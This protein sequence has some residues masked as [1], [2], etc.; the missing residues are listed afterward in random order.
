MNDDAKSSIEPDSQSSLT[1]DNQPLTETDTH[2]KVQALI[3]YSLMSIGLF[4][5]LFW[6]IGGIWAIFKRADAVNSRYHSH[7]N[8]AVKVFWYGLIW[9]L[10]GLMLSQV[11]VGYLI[12]AFI[13]IWAMYR[14]VKGFALITSDKPFV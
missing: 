7:F 13:Y 3:S 14:L 11:L 8:N 4:T 6:I 2:S 9:S 5:G 1:V 10:I 12:L